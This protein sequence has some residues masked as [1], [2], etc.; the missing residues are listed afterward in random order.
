ME[1]EL[2]QATLDEM[3]DLQEEQSEA[4]QE[5]QAELSEEMKELYGTPNQEEKQNQHSFLHKA[6]FENDNTIRTTYL[7]Q[8]EIGRPDFS[9][10]FLQSIKTISEQELDEITEK[11]GCLN[12]IA[13]YFDAKIKNITD[14]GMSNE[15]FAMKLNVTRNINTTKIKKRAGNIENLGGNK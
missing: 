8:N 4:M 5:N 10:R 14:S 7:N 6:T 15:G 2:N 3:E 11:I 13:Q 1:Q 12:I 9:V